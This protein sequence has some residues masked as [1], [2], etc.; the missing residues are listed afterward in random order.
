MD[1]G[2]DR[3]PLSAIL[4]ARQGAAKEQ[5]EA[6]LHL[7][8]VV[9]RYG[10]V[11]GMER[12][13]WELTRELA[14]LGH[15]VGI[16]CEE[17]C[18]PAAPPG[19]EAFPLGTLRPRP[20]WIAYLRFSR[21]V[22]RW[23]ESR[24]SEPWLIHSHERTGSHHVT[25]F[26]GPPFAALRDRPLWRRASL[27]VAANLWMERREV[28]GTT[29]RAVVPNSRVIAD[30]LRKYYPDV[31]AKQV[32]PIAPGVSPSPARPSRAVPGDG[33][34]VGFVGYE[35]RRKGLEMAVRIASGLA[36]TRPKME[37]WVAG[38]DPG[39]VRH[40]FRN[41]GGAQRLLGK[42]EAADLYPMLDLLLHPALQEPY[43]MVVAEA[44]AAKV[45]VV[46]SD[47]CG[48]AESVTGRHG[49]ILSLHAPMEDWIAACREV[50]ERSDPMP[51]YDRPWARVAKE[52]VRLYRSL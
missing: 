36:R 11:G 51:G 4:F 19:V 24:P 40:L 31:I 43:G 18:A 8:H 32:E 42:T 30:Q 46:V 28:C 6:R 10:P 21:R 45:G 49:A 26:H 38:P 50:L 20:R 44:M 14:A 12:Y 29:V 15:R 1:R 3:V 27:R 37:F 52:Y 16:L 23:V 25:T 13:V 7:L 39:E 41:F 48:V 9:R 5:G 2:E 33:G 34:I 22:R 17:V 35:W 47:A